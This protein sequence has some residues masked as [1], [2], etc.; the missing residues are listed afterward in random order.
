MFPAVA[1]NLE[2]LFVGRDRELEALS[3]HFR[4]AGRLA[5]ING[6]CGV[7]KTALAK[8]SRKFE[9]LVAELLEK[10]GYSVKLTPPSKDGGFDMYA[11]KHEV[12]GQFLYF[13]E[14]K[15]YA[16]PNKVGVQVVRALHGVVQQQRANAG[17]I[18]TTSFFTRGAKEYQD[19][20]K[21]QLQLRDYVELQKW[22]GIV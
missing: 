1:V 4:N 21:Y 9:E 6:T 13:V 2:T 22:L 14:C 16:P 20:M 5:Q 7:G 11:A 3:S 15:R 10:Q 12:L 18:A 17:I 8:S 19:E